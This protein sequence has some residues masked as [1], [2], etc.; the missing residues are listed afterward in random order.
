MPD[1]MQPGE[2]SWQALSLLRRCF[3]VGAKQLRLDQRFDPL[4]TKTTVDFSHRMS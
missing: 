2:K 1:N 4:Y 3:F